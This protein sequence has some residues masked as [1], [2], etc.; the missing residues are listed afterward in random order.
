MASVR[1]VQ[2]LLIAAALSAMVIVLSVLGTAVM[3]VG[4]VV[5]VV[6]LVVMVLATLLTAPAARAR[7]G[8]WWLLLAAGAL[9]SIAGALIAQVAET[10]GGWIAVIGGVL[11]IVAAAIGFPRRGGHR[12]RAVAMRRNPLGSPSVDGR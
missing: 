12:G 5:M 3:V 1:L 11:V 6:G 10:P 2:V 7:G 9:L 4:L 8:G